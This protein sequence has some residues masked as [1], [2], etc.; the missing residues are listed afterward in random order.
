M[1][2][3]PEENKFIYSLKKIIPFTTIFSS[4][5]STLLLT[6]LVVTGKMQVFFFETETWTSIHEWKVIIII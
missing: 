3:D 4:L 1:T 6:V 5:T 2:P